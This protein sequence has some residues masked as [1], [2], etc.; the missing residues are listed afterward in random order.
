MGERVSFASKKNSGFFTYF[1]VAGI[2]QNKQPHQAMYYFGSF[3]PAVS[4]VISWNAWGFG[5]P[6]GDKGE[7]TNGYLTRAPGNEHIKNTNV[8]RWED[9]HFLESQMVIG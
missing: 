6:G 4:L 8:F 2:L 7:G 3:E 1:L 9:E 5:F